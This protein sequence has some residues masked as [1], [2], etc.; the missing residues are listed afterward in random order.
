MAVRRWHQ[1]GVRRWTAKGTRTAVIEST[2]AARHGS[3]AMLKVTA[4]TTVA[5]VAV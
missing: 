2:V 3:C 5:V 1:V 4:V